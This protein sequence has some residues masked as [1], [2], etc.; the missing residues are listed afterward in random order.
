MK[1]P[2]VFYEDVMGSQGYVFGAIG[3]VA[4]NY[5]TCEK[6]GANKFRK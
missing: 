2:T 3:I 5:P 4:K 1:G 6:S